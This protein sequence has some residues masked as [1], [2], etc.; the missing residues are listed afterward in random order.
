MREKFFTRIALNL[1]YNF[2]HLFVNY[3]LLRTFVSE[4]SIIAYVGT[5]IG[6]FSMFIDLGFASIYTQHNADKD[7]ESYFSVLVLLKTTIVLSSFVPLIIFAFFA[8]FSQTTLVFLILNVVYIM[9]IHISMPWMVN[10]ESKKKMIKY[11]LIDF[12]ANIITDS[13]SLIVILNYNRLNIPLELIGIS[14]IFAG[15]VKVVLIFFISRGEFVLKKIEWTIIKKFLKAARPLIL[16]FVANAI[17]LN[18]GRLFIGGSQGDDALKDYYA[19]DKNVVNFLFLISAQI[20]LLFSSYFPESF[21]TGKTE[22]IKEMTH[23]VEKYSSILFMALV[24]VILPNSVILLQLILPEYVNSA[25]YL[26]ILIIVPYIVGISNPYMAHLIPSKRQGLYSKYNFVKA[27]FYVISVIIVV[28]T[29]FFSIKMM[30]LGGVGLAFITL[31][32]WMPDIFFYRYFSHKIGI[33][34]NKKTFYHI[35]FGVISILVSFVMY[36]T[37]RNI[38]LFLN[39]LLF[40]IVNAG[41]A[42]GV[43]LVLLIISKEL[44]RKDLNFVFGLFRISSYRESLKDEINKKND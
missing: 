36:F 2:Y 11:S 21:K 43:F 16:Y 1:G 41:L 18:L 13:L 39:D 40:L 24:I 44:T 28:P 27:V 12:T 29:E 8:G 26:S 9:I 15:S 6:L 31:F 34:Y 20:Y 32:I 4:Y 33:D 30:G 42:L 7:F 37:I 17:I 10:L 35:G 19:I 38:P 3:L 23:F 22:D 25:P 5:V 14:M